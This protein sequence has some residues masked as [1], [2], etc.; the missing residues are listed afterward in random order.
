M[1]EESFE[2]DRF[3]EIDSLVITLGLFCSQSLIESSCVDRFRVV[4]QESFLARL[5]RSCASGS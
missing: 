2:I 1:A 4:A 5:G 3:V